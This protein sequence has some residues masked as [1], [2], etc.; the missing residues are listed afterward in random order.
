MFQPQ[1]EE[2]TVA[3]K[4]LAEPWKSEA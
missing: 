4:A 1:T 2:I 3:S